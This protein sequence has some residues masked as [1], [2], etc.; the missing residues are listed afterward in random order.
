MKLNIKVTAI[1][2]LFATISGNAQQDPQYTQY[3]YN[4]LTVNPAYTGSTGSLEAVLLHR[5]QWTGIDGAPETQAFTIHTPLANEKVGLG[6]SA[7]RD[8]IGPSDELQLEGNFSYTLGLDY[9]KKLAFGLKAGMRMFNVDWT[10]GRYYDPMD[11]LLNNNINNEIK[12]SLGAGVYYYTDKWYMGFSVPNFITGNYYDDIQESID[13]NRLHYYLI[14]GYVFDLSD[15]LKFKP[16]RTVTDTMEHYAIYLAIHGY[17]ISKNKQKAKAE[18]KKCDLSGLDN[19][20]KEIKDVINEIIKEDETVETKT[21]SFK[22]NYKKT[23]EN[24]NKDNE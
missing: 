3:M 24:D 17:T 11:A 10:K 23:T 18:L 2:L 15:N 22:K 13:H 14:G 19:F 1:V 12:P 6:L 16:W 7:V 5:S 9:D 20:Q 21:T 4:T 8:K